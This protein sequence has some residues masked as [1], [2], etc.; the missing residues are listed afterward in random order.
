VRSSEDAGVVRPQPDRFEEWLRVPVPGR[1]SDPRFEVRRAELRD[2]PAIYALVDQVFGVVRPRAQYDWLYRDNPSGRARVW[3]VIET[4]TG[5]LVGTS[6][7]WPWP[8]AHGAVPAQAV[9]E[10]DAAVA[11]D[12][13]RQGV[14]QRWQEVADTDPLR[15]TGVS[16]SWPNEISRERIRRGKVHVGYAAW[17]PGWIL[18][19]SGRARLQRRGWPR[20]LASLFGPT[21]DAWRRLRPT[22]A[23][24]GA[25]LRIEAISHFDPAFDLV[26]ARCMGS[27]GHWLPHGADFLNWRYP[28]HPTHEYRCLALHAGGEPRGYSVVRLD[29]RRA[30]RMELATPD[31]AGAALLLAGAAQTARA[32]DCRRLEFFSTEGWRHA[33]LLCEAGFELRPRRSMVGLHD[34]EGGALHAEDW[35]LVPGDN[36]S[37]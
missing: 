22:A 1:C 28:S 2:F 20:P 11:K 29:R 32:A 14:S 3:I 7:A 25:G 17:L 12:M 36:E 35:Q 33:G 26:T 4:A 15:H 23:R 6:A 27:P 30:R 8:A 34:N 24:G 21:A 16:I 13:Q 10:G 19:L 18:D 9:S 37:L 31:A 5:R